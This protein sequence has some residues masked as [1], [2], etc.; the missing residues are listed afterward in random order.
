[1]HPV[2]SL[3]QSSGRL[4]GAEKL[5]AVDECWGPLCIA[6]QSF[7]ETDTI[8]IWCHFGP[9]KYILWV[10]LVLAPVHILICTTDLNVIT[11]SIEGGIIGVEAV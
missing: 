2:Q 10:V 8:L 4:N 5:T 6:V 7:L 1:V 3:R 9:R 11:E